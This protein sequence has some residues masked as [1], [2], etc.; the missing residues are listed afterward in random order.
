M[1][2]PALRRVSR[3]W[4]AAARAS[5]ELAEDP[6]HRDEFLTAARVIEREVIAFRASEA[7]WPTVA[8]VADALP[9]VPG[10]GAAG[11]TQPESPA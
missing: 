9:S 2:T 10:V 7:R 3:L 11:V 5:M 8:E 4:L 6:S 1:T